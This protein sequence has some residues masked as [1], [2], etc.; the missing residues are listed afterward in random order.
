MTVV[1]TPVD[2]NEIVR[3]VKKPAAHDPHALIAR[4]HLR[5]I[6]TRERAAYRQ[7]LFGEVKWRM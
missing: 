6:A 2:F 4:Q 3:A 1:G 7:T 5:R